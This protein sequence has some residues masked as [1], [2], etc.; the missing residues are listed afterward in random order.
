MPLHFRKGILK[1]I[2][3]V[4]MLVNMNTLRQPARKD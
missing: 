3:S 4:C 1:T 2:D